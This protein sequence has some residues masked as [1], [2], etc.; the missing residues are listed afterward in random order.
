[1]G[2]GGSISEGVRFD[3][4]V[5]DGAAAQRDEAFPVHHHNHQAPDETH[6]APAI[7]ADVDGEGLHDWGG[8]ADMEP[9]VAGGGDGDGI[10]DYDGLGFHEGHELGDAHPIDTPVDFD[11]LEEPLDDEAGFTKPKGSSSGIEVPKSHT[12][13]PEP[14]PTP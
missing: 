3:T 14:H 1:M 12:P 2:H 8:G 7:P 10:F 13:N 4:G 11:D 6:Q 5:P 9:A